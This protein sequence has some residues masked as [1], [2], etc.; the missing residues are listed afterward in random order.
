MEK[1]LKERFLKVYANV[2]LGIRN[3][4]ILLLGDQKKPISWDVAYFA[5]R[6]N[7]EES[8]EILEKLE[9]MKLI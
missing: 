5:I 8:K 4:I 7:T 3:E 6:E 1:D 9:K 2:P